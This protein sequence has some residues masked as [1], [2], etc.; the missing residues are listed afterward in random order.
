MHDRLW[1]DNYTSTNCFFASSY[2]VRRVANDL[3]NSRILR[4]TTSR[5]Y[6][7]TVEVIFYVICK[8]VKEYIIIMIDVSVITCG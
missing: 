6:L 3:P 1:P 4:F 7:F 8:L 5:N 2:I